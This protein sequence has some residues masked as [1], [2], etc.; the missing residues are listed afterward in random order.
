MDPCPFVGCCLLIYLWR[1][2]ATVPDLIINLWLADSGLRVARAAGNENR[3]F[4][5]VGM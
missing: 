5:R 1:G 4:G 2:G 3:I